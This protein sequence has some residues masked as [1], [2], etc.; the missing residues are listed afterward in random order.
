MELLIVFVVLAVAALV[1][2]LYARYGY[3]RARDPDLQ[4]SARTPAASRRKL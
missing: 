1:A 4:P 3:R 2:C